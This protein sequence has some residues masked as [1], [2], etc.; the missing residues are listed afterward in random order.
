MA[1]EKKRY[2]LYYG[3][4][5]FPLRNKGL[6]DGYEGGSGTLKVHLET[7]DWITITVGDG[8][9]VAVV[10]ETVKPAKVRVARVL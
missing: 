6:L 1:D 3:G 2:V 4:Q 7:G 5:K 9:P 10:E 8:I